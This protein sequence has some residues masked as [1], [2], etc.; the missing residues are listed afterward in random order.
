MAAPVAGH[1]VARRREQVGGQRRVVPVVGV[2]DELDGADVVDRGQLGVA[3]E[4]RADRDRGEPGPAAMLELEAEV[5]GEREDAVGRCRRGEQ[6]VDGVPIDVAVGPRD[7]RSVHR[8]D[9]TALGHP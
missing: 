9:D 3:R 2:D 5:I 1:D 6:P 4:G 7:L 8:G